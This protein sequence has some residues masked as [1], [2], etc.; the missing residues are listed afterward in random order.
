MPTEMSGWLFSRIIN[1]TGLRTE[2]ARFAVGTR[3]IKRACVG[4]CHGV[5]TYCVHQLS[6]QPGYDTIS[7]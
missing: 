3:G 2:P 5:E 1:E 6:R 4:Y 7:K